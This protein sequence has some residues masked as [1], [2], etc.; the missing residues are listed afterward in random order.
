MQTQSIS[1]PPTTAAPPVAAPVVLDAPVAQN[2]LPTDA[3]GANNTWTADPQVAPLLKRMVKRPPALERYEGWSDSSWGKKTYRRYTGARYRALCAIWQA[4]GDAVFAED[5]YDPTAA[6]EWVKA[7]RPHHLVEY[8]LGAYIDYRGDN[9]AA[10]IAK[11]EA[12]MPSL[13][14]G[15][16][17]M[18]ADAQ[19]DRL[20]VPA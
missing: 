2:Y 17:Q 19:A 6:A 9:R 15:R 8:A 7:P 20:A 16:L 18:L 11:C 1:Q 10:Y 12:S 13:A 3:A 5:G 14:P 4:Y